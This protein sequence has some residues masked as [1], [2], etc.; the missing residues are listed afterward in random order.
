MRTRAL[1]VA[2]L[3]A[4][5]FLPGC[6]GGGGGVTSPSS[7]QATRKVMTQRNWEL[8]VNQFMGADLSITGSGTGTVDAIV[9]WTY[10]SNDVDIYVT[11]ANCSTDAF[12]TSSCAYVAKA[13][14]TTAKPERLSFPVT[15]ASTYRL[16]V[17]NF[18]PTQESGTLEVGLT[19]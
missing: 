18:G 4:A 6:G 5:P 15:G 1:C 2:A 7:S 19:Q 17:V 10:P 14:S 16:W 8:A 12:S 11:A 9:E 3:L 13:D